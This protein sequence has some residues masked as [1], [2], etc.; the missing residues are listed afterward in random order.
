MCVWSCCVFSSVFSGVSQ[1]QFVSAAVP[2]ASDL[3]PVIP[4]MPVSHQTLMVILCRMLLAL[5][6]CL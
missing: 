5:R 6:L 2:N 1:Q 4:V 3:F